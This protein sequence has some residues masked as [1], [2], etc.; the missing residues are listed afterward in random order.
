MEDDPFRSLSPLN[1]VTTDNDP[2]IIHMNI[3]PLFE[4]SYVRPFIA[5]EREQATEREPNRDRESGTDQGDYL[6]LGEE[7]SEAKTTSTNRNRSRNTTRPHNRSSQ[8]SNSPLSQFFDNQSQNRS[9]S[10]D[11]TGSQSPINNPLFAFP[12]RSS[13]SRSQSHSRIGNRNRSRSGSRSRSRSH[14][15]K[16]SNRER[17]E[18]GETG[19]TNEIKGD[20]DDNDEGNESE[21][22]PIRPSNLSTDRDFKR[23]AQPQSNDD[24]KN[25]TKRFYDEEYIDEYGSRSGTM[26]DLPEDCED[27][28]DIDDEKYKAPV[29]RSA[30]VDAEA[31]EAKEA[32]G[33][34]DN[35]D[36]D[37]HKRKVTR[38]PCK[39]HLVGNRSITAFKHALFKHVCEYVKEKRKNPQGSVLFRTD[40]SIDSYLREI[41]RRI[42]DFTDTVGLAQYSM[43]AGF[44]CG[45]YI[46]FNC[47]HTIVRDALAE[48]LKD[49]GIDLGPRRDWNNKSDII[50]RAVMPDVMFD[51]TNYIKSTREHGNRGRENKNRNEDR[52]GGNPRN[53][54]P[55]EVECG[56]QTTIAREQRIQEA[57]VRQAA[58]QEE[59]DSKRGGGGGEGGG[60]GGGA[61]G[62]NEEFPSYEAFLDRSHNSLLDRMSRLSIEAQNNNNNNNPRNGD[63]DV[64]NAVH[65]R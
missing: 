3:E 15:S 5:P 1:D 60:G 13:R 32:E 43:N 39:D 11:R 50:T 31:K 20:D 29:R 2:N 37:E 24:D 22:E 48:Y 12:E 23:N 64:A 49:K 9:R 7:R 6:G 19:Q 18:S 34:V 27:P 55:D 17:E 59:G 46:M 61:D 53:M 44:D 65:R 47:K 54:A 56:K 63:D 28:G 36:N 62:N 35:A 21:A 26:H 10:R 16:R 58:F 51:F 42:F 8:R 40:E 57:R 30:L 41:R 52:P 14:E 38:K 45:H 4:Q 25:A 33:D